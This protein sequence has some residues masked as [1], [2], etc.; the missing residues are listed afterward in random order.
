[1]IGKTSILVIC[2]E[3]LLVTGCTDLRPL[4]MLGST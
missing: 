2:L 3:I 1:M 4:Q